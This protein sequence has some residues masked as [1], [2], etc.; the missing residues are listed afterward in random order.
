MLQA[1]CVKC[2]KKVKISSPKNVTLK[3]RGGTRKA[4]KGKCSLCGTK[5]FR[6]TGNEVR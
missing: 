5:V 6:I 4:I 3:S 1:Y 2:R